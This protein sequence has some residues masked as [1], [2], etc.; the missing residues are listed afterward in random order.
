MAADVGRL[1]SGHGTSNL[2]LQNKHIA[3]QSIKSTAERSSYSIQ[4]SIDPKGK[5]GRASVMKKD[6]MT[7]HIQPCV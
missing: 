3:G 2:R 7:Q 4:T 5:T 6:P 1:Y